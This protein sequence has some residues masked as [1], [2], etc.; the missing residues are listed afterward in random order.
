MA[1]TYQKSTSMLDYLKSVEISVKNDFIHADKSEGFI[2][3]PINDKDRV[4]LYVTKVDGVVAGCVVA[5]ELKKDDYKMFKEFIP[6]QNAKFID[7]LVIKNW[8][9][10]NGLGQ[11]LVNFIC[12]EF[13]S[14]PIYTVIRLDPDKNMGAVKIAN[15]LGFKQISQIEYF[16]KDFM[17][18]ATWGLFELKAKLILQDTIV[19]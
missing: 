4:D 18:N 14:Y 19:E 15:N 8:H 12:N 10:K 17:D 6:E 1:T 11:N 3:K 7:K 5:R 9:R 2:F 13:E 16:N